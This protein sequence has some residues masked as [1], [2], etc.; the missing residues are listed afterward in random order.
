M[1]SVETTGGCWI[2]ASRPCHWIRV[3]WVQLYIVLVFCFLEMFFKLS[4]TKTWESR[5]IAGDYVTPE[6]TTFFSHEHGRSLTVTWPQELYFFV[7]RYPLFF[8]V[9]YKRL[10]SHKWQSNKGQ[11]G[12]STMVLESSHYPCDAGSLHEQ[13]QLHQGADLHHPPQ[14]HVWWH[15]GKGGVS[16][17]GKACGLYFFKNGIDMII[18]LKVVLDLMTEFQQDAFLACFSETVSPQIFQYATTQV[19]DKLLEAGF[20][21]KVFFLQC[22]FTNN[23]W[24]Q[25][26]NWGMEGQPWANGPLAPKVPAGG[27]SFW[28]SSPKGSSAQVMQDGIQ[29]AFGNSP[30]RTWQMA[31]RPSPQL[32]DLNLLDF[33]LGFFFGATFLK[34]AYWMYVWHLRPGLA[35][36]PQE[37]WQCFHPWI[38]WRSSAALR[39]WCR[40]RS[41][42]R[43]LCSYWWPRTERRWPSPVFGATSFEWGQLQA[44]VP[45]CWSHDCCYLEHG[46][47]AEYYM[48]FGW[49]QGLP[50]HRQ[51]GDGLWGRD[52]KRKAPLHVCW[53]DMDFWGCKGH[54]RKKQVEH[55]L[56]HVLFEVRQRTRKHVTI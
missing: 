40:P 44:E 16:K 1:S 32:L 24:K 17:K 45:K 6:S 3:N 54:E 28:P 47:W 20:V 22:D 31:G 25:K 18:A 14:K 29:R 15:F 26:N 43:D 23:S 41:C 12:D 9:P 38:W 53:R 8:C 11:G 56:K 48:Y 50:Q 37:L 7:P 35:S 33:L 55:F 5:V 51:Q 30:W 36:S 46:K 42:N 19:K 2:A 21:H 49:Q 10:Q 27:R 39:R 4:E 34:H 52:Y 13:S